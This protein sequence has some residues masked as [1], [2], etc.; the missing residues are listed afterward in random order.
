MTGLRIKLLPVFEQVDEDVLARLEQHV[1][2]RLYPSN[3]VVYR[4][5]APCDGLYGVVKGSVLVRTERPGQPVDR[6]L[7]L[8]PGDVFGEVETVEDAPREYTARVFKAAHLLWIPRPP[9]RQILAA[10]PFLGTLLRTLGARRK[11][12]Q[13]RTRFTSAT[14]REQRIWVDREVVMTLDGGARVPVR[15][16]DLSYSGACLSAVPRFWQAGQRLS[17][18]LGIQERPDLLRI[19]GVVCWHDIHSLGMSFE[20]SGPQ[21][22]QKV[23]QALQVLVAV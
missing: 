14:R 3:E 7:D 20:N 13:T 22:R 16:E 1:Q 12:L 17:F 18:T 23:D 4:T 2:E 8:G 6:F 9:L 5:G 21:L 11:I 15:L 10:H 19:Q